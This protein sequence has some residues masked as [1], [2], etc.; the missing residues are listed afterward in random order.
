MSSNLYSQG[1]GTTSSLSF[2]A[3]AIVVPRSPT[4][5]DIQSNLGQYPI[6]QL[7]VDTQNSSSWQLVGYS[8]T[9]GVV[10]ATWSLVGGSSSDVNTLSGD[11]GVAVPTAGNIQIAG[12][13]GVTTAASGSVVTVSLI[14]GHDA[15]EQINVDASTPPGTNPVIPDS[16]GRIT[17]TG[18]QVAAGTTTNVIRTDSLAANVY[19]IE[20]QRSQAVASST[21]GDNGVSHFNSS[22]FTVDGNGF[23]SL[24][25]GGQAIDSI[26]VDSAIAPGTNPVLPDGAGLITVT[27]GQIAAASTANAIRTQSIAANSYIVQ[28]QRSKTEV[29][30]TVASNG[31]SHF[32]NNYF[33]VDSNGFVS[34]KAIDEVVWNTTSTNIANMV[35]Q[36]GYFCISPGGA[37]TLGLPAT[38]VLGDLIEVVLAGATSFQI[39]Q[40]AGQ[41]VVVGNQTTTAGVGGSITSTSQGDS[42]KLVCLTP[43][44]KWY[45]TSSIGNF[46]IA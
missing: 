2:P 17:V 26:G 36:N 15:V 23:V 43:N 28:V 41:Q 5:S 9:N 4:S 30:S 14:G 10:S 21:I 22:H 32:D 3:N 11:T 46:T 18:D 19:T 20:I 29:T 33:S 34:L 39:T 27:G 6:G 44:L 13:A 45:A 38:S 16:L 25:G 24:S 1:Y 35:V 8:V 40:S 12:G 31:I 7:W 37:L 42:I